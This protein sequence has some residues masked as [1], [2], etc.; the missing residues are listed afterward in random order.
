MA[1]AT[2]KTESRKTGIVLELTPEEAI[3]VRLVLGQMNLGDTYGPFDV[4]QELVNVP[5]LTALDD[6]ISFGETGIYFTDRGR[7]VIKEYAE[8][9]RNS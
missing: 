4:I 3:A 5:A 1:K 6:T 2:V 9:F 8:K 7:E